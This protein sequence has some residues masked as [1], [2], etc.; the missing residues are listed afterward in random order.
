MKATSL[1]VYC[2]ILGILCWGNLVWEKHGRAV[3]SKTRESLSVE[4]INL[5][6]DSKLTQPVFSVQTAQANSYSASKL[7]G[8]GIAH[9]LKGELEEAVQL[10][11]RAIKIDPN[12]ADAYNNLGNALAMMGKNEEAIEAF[13]RSIELYPDNELAASPYYNLGLALISIGQWEK[14]TKAFCQ[15][16]S[17]DPNFDSPQYN[18]AKALSEQGSDG[19]QLDV[20]TFCQ[21]Y[22]GIDVSVDRQ[23]LP[24]C[25]L[26]PEVWAEGGILRSEAVINC[27]GSR[28]YL[29]FLQALEEGV[30]AEEVGDYIK[31]ESATR[32]L[33][34]MAPNFSHGWYL[35]GNAFQ[36]QGKLK[37]A[38]GAWE[39]AIRLNPKIDHAYYL[40]GVTMEQQGKTEEAVSYFRQAL[41]M[42]P[43]DEEYLNALQ[44]AQRKLELHRQQQ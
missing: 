3:A 17:L 27:L 21:Q 20:K 7:V 39:E 33:V 10:F 19:Q 25:H 6:Q 15:A 12:S 28:G 30:N 22:Y 36:Q 41:Q 38:I 40:L 35:L 31:V 1:F 2:A 29:L 44:E 13:R 11:R 34:Q 8:E 14:G 26:P 32:K 23:K 37:E 5:D 9:A 18:L 24:I 43:Q 16:I 4:F 42:V